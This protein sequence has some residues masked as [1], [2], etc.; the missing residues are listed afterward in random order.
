MQIEPGQSSLCWPKQSRLAQ[1]KSIPVE[2][3]QTLISALEPD[4]RFRAQTRSQKE[5]VQILPLPLRNQGTW[6]QCLK[7][8]VPQFLHV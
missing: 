2:V 7:L 5:E 4:A 6:G 8:S 1:L 3:V